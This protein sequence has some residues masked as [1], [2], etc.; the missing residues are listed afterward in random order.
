MKTLKIDGLKVNN[1]DIR[2]LLG[3]F[4]EINKPDII[5]NVQ[6]RSSSE[7]TFDIKV[8]YEGKLILPFSES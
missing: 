7:T 8:H 5:K 6:A 3:Q 1:G 4:W 2:G